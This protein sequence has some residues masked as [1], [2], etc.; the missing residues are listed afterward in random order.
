MKELMNWLNDSG[1]TT[2]RNQK[3]T[4]NSV[5]KLLTNKR[6][7]GENHFKDIVMPDSIRPSWTRTCLKKCSKKSRRTAAL[8]PVTRPRTITCSPPSC[9]VE[10]AAP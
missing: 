4:Y 5:Q 3:F 8:L 1:V 6:Y 7:I 2:N 9:S 10:C